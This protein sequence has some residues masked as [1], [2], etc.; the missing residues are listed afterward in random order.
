[1]GHEGGNETET[2]QAIGELG[3]LAVMAHPHAP[4][5]HPAE[6]SDPEWYIP[7]YENYPHLIGQEIT[8]PSQGASHINAHTVIWDYLLQK[9]MPDRKIFG[10]SNSDA[11]NI[12]EI[13]TAYNIILAENKT[14]SKVR[15]AL[16]DGNSLAVWVDNKNNNPPTLNSISAEDGNIVISADSY[17]E[18]YWVIDGV[19][20]GTGESFDVNDLSLEYNYVRAAIEGA[21]G[22]IYTQPFAIEK[23]QWF[24]GSYMDG[25]FVTGNFVTGSFA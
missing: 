13:G 8:I 23:K 11:H 9:L 25:N 5:Y 12:S 18:I 20:V 2:I 6:A 7:F 1:L 16:E 19:V 3:G 17:T 22:R 21:N 24:N 15:S 4:I 14:D 10:Y